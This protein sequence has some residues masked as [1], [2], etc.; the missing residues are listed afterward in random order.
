MQECRIALISGL[1][2]AA[3]TISVAAK[4]KPVIEHHRGLHADHCFIS[5]SQPAGP[6]KSNLNR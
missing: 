1:P 4:G 6:A 3:I 5:Y 2:F